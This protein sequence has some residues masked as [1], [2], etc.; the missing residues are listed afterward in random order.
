MSKFLVQ[1]S[2]THIRVPGA[3]AYG[4]VDTAGFLARAVAQVRAL[5]QPDAVIVTGDLTDFGRA[6]EYAHLRSLLAPLTCPVYLMPG[7]HDDRAQLRLAFA[8]HR[9]LRQGAAG[10][11]DP[12]QY[13]VDLGG[14]RLVAADSVVPRATHGALDEPRLAQLERLLAASP[15][16]P[17][18]LAMHH[19]P[20][21]TGIDQMDEIV[22]LEGAEALA[23]LVARYPSIERIICGH[24]HR[25][26]QARFAHTIA[27]TAPST[28]HQVQLDLTSQ[29]EPA[30]VM[31]PPGYLIHAWSEDGRV[32]THQ[33]AIGTFA[34]RIRFPRTVH[35][36]SK[37]ARPRSRG[38]EPNSCGALSDA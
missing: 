23:E 7:N 20:F 37:S 35:W 1:L 8:E 15:G 27:M 33:A 17:T 11:S 34:G 30:F 25:S 9:Y 6:E 22:L 19:P 21:R 10:D 3:L 32:V 5:P 12:I 26:I 14:L 28:A 18:I 38:R 4:R 16:T 29:T 24:L 2:D 13:A 31:E 36:T